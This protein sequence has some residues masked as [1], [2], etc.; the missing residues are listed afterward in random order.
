[1]TGVG[2]RARSLER[3]SVVPLFVVLPVLAAC[4]PAAPRPA[5]A[6]ESEV[7]AVPPAA[8]DDP[9][10][11]LLVRPGAMLEGPAPVALLRGLG[12]ADAVS[13]LFTDHGLDPGA[14]GWVRVERSG[15]GTAFVAAGAAAP[16]LARALDSI[17]EGTPSVPPEGSPPAEARRSWVVVVDG[18][19]GVVRRAAVGSPD[20]PCADDPAASELAR[21]WRRAAAPELLF[22]WRRPPSVAAELDATG[23]LAETR[24]VGCVVAAESAEELRL[25]CVLFGPAGERLSTQSLR[26]LQATVFD[27]TLGM[28]L[29]LE[30]A[31]RAVLVDP[32][33]GAGYLEAVLD[34]AA[35]LPG[36]RVLASVP[37]AHLL[38]GSSS[39][40]GP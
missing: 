16:A 11:V 15:E 4:A 36:L 10:W 17:G 6:P 32:E 7:P 34:V 21:L 5:G 39:S 37:L 33:P 25:G 38:G 40:P 27:S 26:R 24:A 12:I 31:A 29:N 9:G 19:W 13:S 8:F 30:G 20:P 22:L 3:S 1:M 18:A 14:L 2:S 23:L 28:I 35:L